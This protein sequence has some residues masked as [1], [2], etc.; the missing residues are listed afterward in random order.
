[1]HGHGCQNYTIF[2]TFVISTSCTNIICTQTGII[3]RWDTAAVARGDTDIA[4]TCIPPHHILYIMLMLHSLF[5]LYRLGHVEH[6]WCKTISQNFCIPFV[7]MC[8]HEIISNEHN[9]KMCTAHYNNVINIWDKA[10]VIM[11]CRNRMSQYYR[12]D[13]HQRTSGEKW[14]PYP[15][16]MII[17]SWGL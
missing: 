15:W 3:K 7:I 11:Q 8:T 14:P 12:S 5:N 13:K 16:P 1:M 2:C 9:G 10:A 17:I 6:Y 4:G